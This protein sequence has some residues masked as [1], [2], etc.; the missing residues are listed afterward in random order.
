MKITFPSF[1]P[2]LNVSKREVIKY[3][4][5]VFA[6][7][8]FSRAALALAGPAS[9]A[10]IS[11]ELAKRVSDTVDQDTDRLVAIFKDFHQNPELG[12]QE[13]RT[14]G[15]VAKEL[16]D[17][18]FEVKTGIGTT[19]VAGIMRNGDGPTVLFRGDMDAIPVEEATGVDYA[20]IATGTLPD[21]TE[22]PVAHQCGHDAH[23]TWMLSVAKTMATLKDS[24]KGTLVVV[25]QQSEETLEGATQMVEDGMYTTHGVPK[26]DF[27]LSMHTAP[28]PLGLLVGSSGPIMA[29]SDILEVT[30]FGVGGHGSVPQ[31]TKDPVIMATYAI[32][33]YQTIISRVLDPREPAVITVGS[34]KAGKVANVIPETATLAVNTRYFKT[35]IG[36]QL[37]EDITRVSEGIAR[38]YG[39]PE[40]KLPTVVRKGR[41]S[42]NVNDEQLTERTNAAVL[43][44]GLVSEQ[45]LIKEFPAVTGSEDFVNLFDGLDDVKSVYKF[46]GIV[47]EETWAKTQ[48]E[49]KQVPWSNHNPEFLV[50]L[51]AIPLGGKIASTMVLDLMA[52]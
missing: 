27:A 26:P 52:T 21:G 28:G 29:G 4:L 9:S 41:A 11:P 31:H 14:A 42:V 25:G 35:E 5:A 34:I 17:L 33:Q 24:W 47:S 2:Y 12:F 3:A 32:A 13:T 8:P 43:A 1:Q 15:I 16:E 6:A 10:T 36:D 44:S 7:L 30:F 46:L 49:G 39:M 38:T 45:T 20:S 23:T 51:K 48:A 50:D 18:G 22:T 19:G 37:I 40:D